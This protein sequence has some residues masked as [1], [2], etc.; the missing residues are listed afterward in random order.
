MVELAVIE[1]YRCAT[2]TRGQGVD[3]IGSTTPFDALLLVEWPLPWPRDIAEIE[4]LSD[5]TADRRASVFAVVPQG[6]T[7]DARTGTGLA[8]V[9]HRRRVGSHRLEGVDH[10]VPR[11][12]VRALLATILE[13]VE[14]DHLDL[15]SAVGPAPTDLLVCGHGR[16]D[17]CCGRWGTLLQAELAARLTDVRVWRC[18]HTGG[19]RFAPTAISATDG[20]AWAFTDADLLVGVLDH[21]IPVAALA[22]HHR[23]SAAVPMWAQPVEHALL[24][25]YGWEWTDQEIT[26][27]E[28]DVADDKRGATVRLA[29][30]TPDGAGFEARAEVVVTREIPVLV[31]G[32]PPEAAEKSSLEL[33]VSQLEIVEP[34]AALP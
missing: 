25:R 26:A 17:R 21:S 16:R 33:A 5:A 31:C 1:D 12:E 10:V 34:R 13:D 15:P 28:I 14:A 7:G 30:T 8:R 2:W 9:V 24:L 4:A 18:S 27:V 29:W 19:H 6:D 23:G 22:G 11:D 3:P 32:E 20:R